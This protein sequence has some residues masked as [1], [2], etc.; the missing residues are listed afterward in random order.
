MR[1]PASEPDPAGSLIDRAEVLL[2]LGRP[3]E[4]IPLLQQAAVLAPDDCNPHC[5]MGLALFRLGKHA[6]AL[7]AVGRGAAVAPD[8]EWPHRLRSIILRDQGRFRPAMEAAR[9]AVRLAPDDQNTLH[10]L[11]TSEVDAKQYPQALETALRLR[12][13]APEWDSA[14]TLLGNI[15]LYFKRWDEAEAHCRRALELNPES[16][17]SLF[18][19]AYIRQMTGRKREAAD[20]YHTILRIDPSDAEARRAL[21]L[22][23]DRDMSELP[24]WKRKKRLEE[25]HPTVQA[26]V[27]EAQQRSNRE[28][29]ETLAAGWVILGWV[30]SLGWT[31]FVIG[32][33]WH[34]GLMHRWWEWS[35]Y[36]ATLLATLLGTAGLIRKRREGR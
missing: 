9:E 28:V 14:H 32:F 24:I 3:V 8:Y 2:D 15:T 5:W 19:L 23:V 22:L 35:A 21:L 17:T 7:Q 36:A 6:E 27:T 10:L 25:E 18:N 4:A 34:G 16:R 26:F 29:N 13:V 31:A 20:F 30:F 1:V 11:A 12:E 33:M